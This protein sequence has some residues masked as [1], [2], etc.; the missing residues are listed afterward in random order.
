[1]VVINQG[2]QTTIKTTTDGVNGEVQHVNIDTVAAGSLANIGVIHNAGTLANGSLANLALA[3]TVG[4]VGSVTAIGVLHS[5]GTLVNGSLA[6]IALVHT[7]GTVGSV[8]GV[9]TITT[10]GTQI[11]LGVVTNLTSG[12]VRI[13]VG[14]ITTGSLTSLAQVYNAG[15]IQGGTIIS[16]NLQFRHADQYATV[17]SSGTST[18]GTIKAAVSGSA[19]YIT[20]LIVSAGTT[21]NVEIASGGTSTP[22]IGTMHFAA[23]GGLVTNSFKVYPCTASGSALVYKQSVNGPLTISCFGYVD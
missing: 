2:T 15:T 12:S 6:N 20:D 16:D 5:A 4:T 17:V 3:H 7:L 8:T 21:T 18:L 13:T 22:I 11:G 14:T 19:I 23:N 1:M 9:G 10:I